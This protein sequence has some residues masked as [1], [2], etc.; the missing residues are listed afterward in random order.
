[1]HR[2]D[3]RESF[4]LRPFELWADLPSVMVMGH[5]LVERVYGDGATF[6]NGIMQRIYRDSFGESIN[7][8]DAP[9][10]PKYRRPAPSRR[11]RTPGRL[12][13]DPTS[14]SARMSSRTF[15]FRSTSR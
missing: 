15:A 7:G 3:L 13:R 1:M 9:E 12:L 14:T 2:G 10:H 8:M 6:S 5:S 4:G 11:P